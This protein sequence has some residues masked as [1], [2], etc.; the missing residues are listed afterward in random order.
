[1]MIFYAISI[2]IGRVAQKRKLA[3]EAAAEAAG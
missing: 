1:M 3:R 2:V